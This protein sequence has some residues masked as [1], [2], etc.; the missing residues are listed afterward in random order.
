MVVVVVVVTAIDGSPL[1][2]AFLQ[3]QLGFPTHQ[4]IKNVSAVIHGSSHDLVVMAE[5]G[6]L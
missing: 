2:V 3:V 5:A 6:Q 4:P 1:G